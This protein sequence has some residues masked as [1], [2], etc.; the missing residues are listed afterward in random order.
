MPLQKDQNYSQ[1]FDFGARFFTRHQYRLRVGQIISNI[2][3]NAV[4][5]GGG[6]IY[7]SLKYFDNIFELQ[8]ED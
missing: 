3:S 6:E 5:Y 4:K 2:I 1:S 8:I 7:I